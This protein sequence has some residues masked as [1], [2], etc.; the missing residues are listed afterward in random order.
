[1]IEHLH[2]QNVGPA[3]EMSL[4]FGSRLNLITGDNGLGK[5]F[6]LDVIWWALTRKWPHDL[7]DKLT[8]GYPARPT[9]PRVPATIE[10]GLTSKSG[11]VSYKSTYVPRDEAWTGKAGRPWNPGLVIYAHADGGFSVW[12]P[13]R[14]YWKT[15]GRVDVQDRLPGYVFSP[16]EVWSGLEVEIGGKRTVVCN[17]LIRDWATWIREKG[18]AARLMSVV[19]GKLAPAGESLAAGPLVRL[20]INSGQDIPSIQTRY[21]HAVPILHA[22]S[23]VRRAVGL[24]YMLL[25]SWNEHVIAANSL[26]ELPTHQVVVLFDEIESHL[27]PRWQRSILRSVLEVAKVTHGDAQIQ[28]V[29]ATHSPMIMAAAEPLFDPETDA[30]FDLDLDEATGKVDLE[31]CNFVR[32]GDVS[33]WL[34]SEA[35]DLKEPRS[36]EAETAIR[37]TLKLVKQP[38]PSTADVQRVHQ[39]LQASLGDTDRFWLRWTEFEHS[40]GR[41]RPGAKK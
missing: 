26:G 29:A 10:F 11:R 14:N 6:L 28:L 20:S 31:K 21:S 36:L 23:G 3:P 38:D 16:Q 37:E 5:S 25:W 33:S 24:A 18:D 13:A 34:T 41:V 19:L 2:L 1:M 4:D 17:G 32:R 27:H 15:K 12:D 40:R 35:F 8:S 22:S 39:L 9:D 30:W 7:N